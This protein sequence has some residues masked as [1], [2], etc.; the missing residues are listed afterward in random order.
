MKHVLIAL[1]LLSLP[2]LAQKRSN[3]SSSIS[4]DG[5]TL[6]IDIH[7]TVD[8]REIR[9]DHTHAVEGLSSDEKHKLVSDAY[10]SLGLEPPAKPKP[11]VPPAPPSPPIPP[12]GPLSPPSPPTPPSGPPAP[13][14]PP[15]PT[16]EIP[17]DASLLIDEDSREMRVTIERT[18]NGKR[19]VLQ[20]TFD[21]RGKSDAEK[22]RLI[23]SFGKEFDKN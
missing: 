18:T 6:H 16:Y 23:E 8:G 2:A 11:P 4:D 19:K 14:A 13:P 7:G 15:V 5:K 9:Y 20:K 21:V 1:S 12:A 10:T 17:R 3:L 22:R